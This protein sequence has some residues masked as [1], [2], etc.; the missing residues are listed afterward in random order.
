[1][2]ALRDV[3]NAAWPGRDS[4]HGLTGAERNLGEQDCQEQGEQP[5][6]RTMKG[7]HFKSPLRVNWRVNRWWMSKPDRRRDS[8]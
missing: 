1:M 8:T 2:I 5:Y 6:R 4:G 3:H 7:F